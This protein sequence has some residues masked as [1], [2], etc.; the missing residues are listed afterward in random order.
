MKLL[1]SQCKKQK[2]KEG[3]FL[4]SILSVSHESVELAITGH[5]ASLA[6]TPQAARSPLAQA[7]QTTG[8]D[9]Q[10]A[11][12]PVPFLLTVVSIDLKPLSWPVTADASFEQVGT[13]PSPGANGCCRT[14][15]SVTNT[16]APRTE[17]HQPDNS[18]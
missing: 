9:L 13:M 10:Q 3:D 16:R 4:L 5:R 2:I 8:S 15:H 17:N 7:D 18:H 11:T 6:G 1:E 14:D 12:T